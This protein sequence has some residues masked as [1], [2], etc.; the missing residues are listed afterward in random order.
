MYLNSGSCLELF[1]ML[2]S[3]GTTQGVLYD[4]IFSSINPEDDTNYIPSNI[5]AGRAD[6]PY[7]IKQALFD[8]KRR[9]EQVLR[10][11][12]KVRPLIEENLETLI[13]AFILFLEKDR[14]IQNTVTIANRQVSEWKVF[15]GTIFV[16]SFLLG[17]MTFAFQRGNKYGNATDGL[18]DSFFEKARRKGKKLRIQEDTTILSPLQLDIPENARF[19]AVF[20]EV[21]LDQSNNKIKLRLFHLDSD[22]SQYSYEGLIRYFRENLFRHVHTLN[23]ING[24][25]NEGRRGSMYLDARTKLAETQKEAKSNLLDTLL[26]EACITDAS[27]APKIVNLLEHDSSGIPSGSH[28]IHYLKKSSNAGNKVIIAISAMMDDGNEAIL[29]AFFSIADIATASKSWK[30][31]LFSQSSLLTKMSPEDAKLIAGTFMPNS[32]NQTPPI[33]YGVFIGYS[34]VKPDET[35]TLRERL[36]SEILELSRTIQNEIERSN[37]KSVEFGFYFVPFNNIEND[38]VQIVNE[39]LL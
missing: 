8:K 17:V 35:D 20:H 25:Q 4:A 21:P 15:E 14:T 18:T 7:Q 33:G 9:P 32:A 36:S 34:G 1:N 28:G 16:E 37:L 29:N 3:H 39:V 11:Q 5:K 24:Y 23:E 31:R 26:V 38:K 13:G 12:E 19:Q 27:G 30:T 10:F 6:V 22:C 2:K